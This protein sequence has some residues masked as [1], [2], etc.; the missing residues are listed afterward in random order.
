MTVWIGLR[1]AVHWGILIL[2]TC[3]TVAL[4]MGWT[5]GDQP[6]LSAPGGAEIDFVRDITKCYAT[7]AKP[8]EANWKSYRLEAG[9]LEYNRALETVRAQGKVKMIQRLPIY[10]VITCNEFFSELKREYIKA[11]KEVKIIYDEDTILN[12]DS[13]EWDRQNDWV[14]VTGT[15]QISYKDWRIN[16][17]R[18]EGQVNKGVFVFFGPVK[19]TS[20][21]GSL[22][23]G[24][25]VFD[26]SLD[27]I[28]LKNNPVIIQGKN[29]F[30][31]PEIVYDLK[32][33]KASTKSDGSVN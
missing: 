3:L 10:R 17:E 24:Q 25:I 29:Q 7:D 33:R 1:K 6:K 4:P 23:A 11:E 22:K 9:Y 2:I 20:D 14:A 15:P 21:D 16:G 13:L 30:T 18:I 27:K 32:T 19:G 5:E 26:R 28:F 12:G 8:V 31:A